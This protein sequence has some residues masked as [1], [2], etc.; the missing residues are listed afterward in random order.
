MPSV[1]NTQS[2]NSARLVFPFRAAKLPKAAPN[3]FQRGVEWGKGASCSIP[4]RGIRKGGSDQEG[5]LPDHADRQPRG[6]I[7]QLRSFSVRW[8]EG[9]AV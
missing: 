8:R 9:T 6:V 3:I 7:K 4:Q 2:A 1:V 5:W